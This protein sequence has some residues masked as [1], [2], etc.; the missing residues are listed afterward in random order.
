VVAV[1][2]GGT[3]TR[4]IAGVVFAL[5]ALWALGDVRFI[6]LVRKPDEASA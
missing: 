4:F 6:W 3:V 5:V 2:R 1:G